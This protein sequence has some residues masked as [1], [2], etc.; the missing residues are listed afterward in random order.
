MIKVISVKHILSMD[1]YEKQDPKIMDRVSMIDV[2]EGSLE[3]EELVVIQFE[4]NDKICTVYHAFPGDMPYGY[5]DSDAEQFCFAEGPC[6]HTWE[7]HN[8]KMC[9]AKNPPITEEGRAFFQWYSDFTEDGKNYDVFQ[10]LYM[11]N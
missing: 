8:A 6:M 3:I 1:E 11:K 2:S 9:T 5:F 10:S 7:L 4:I